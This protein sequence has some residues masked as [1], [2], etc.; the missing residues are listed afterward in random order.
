M[1]KAKKSGKVIGMPAT[2]ENQ[3]R[4]RARNLAIGD[5]WI[6]ENWEGM[7]EANVLVT[8][9]H[10][11]GGT[12]FA[13]YLIDLALLGVKDTFYQFNMP[14]SEFDDFI[15][16]YTENEGSVKIDYPFAHNLIYG[17]IAYA[18]EYD[19]HPHKDFAVS[20]YVLEED[21]EEI[22]LIELEFGVDGLPTVFTSAENQRIADIKKM[23]RL[24]G[25]GNFKVIDLGEEPDWDEV[26]SNDQDDLSDMD[27]AEKEEAN[28]I[29]VEAYV[30]LVNWTKLFRLCEQILALKPW[31][32]ISETEIF[33]IKL[34]GNGK[35]YFVSVMGE[36]EE[37]LAITFFEGE[38]AIYKYFELQDGELNYHQTFLLS[39]PH[40]MVSWEER[41]ELEPLQSA[42]MDKMGISYTGK[43]VWPVINQTIPGCIPEIPNIR[44]FEKIE[45]LL[46]QSLD[47]LPRLMSDPSIIYGNPDQPN[48]VLFRVPK[49]VQGEWVWQDK[50]KIPTTEAAFLKV[51]YDSSQL[52]E[53]KRLPVKWKTL[54][55]DIVLQPYPIKGKAGAVN[56]PFMLIALDPKND[57]IIFGLIL[58]SRKRYETNL[59][60]LPN[61][62]ME[63]LTAVGGRPAKFEFRNPDLVVTLRL[64][65]DL[66][67]I[68]SVLNPNLEPL[69]KAVLGIIDEL[70]K[71][72]KRDR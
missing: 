3:I 72:V 30:N 53:F 13:V 5:C 17:A 26:N 50:F 52:A 61:L 14:P 45:I 21:S 48:I 39:I 4:T 25:K 56:F 42:I 68:E 58:D 41:Q 36:N 67:G 23:E 8:R 63:E 12:T 24:V 2:P 9:K 47:M 28:P 37:L 62:I 33:A 66:A 57:L 51:N 40:I 44:S 19:F 64:F 10:N 18:E 29:I 6:T 1:S 15:K 59:K 22:P 49:K 34:P 43:N 69:G 16:D 38:R 31:E 70:G 55:V 11:Q 71:K 60:N 27:D 35:E 7:R 32:K 65:H 46:E 20:Q 54:Q